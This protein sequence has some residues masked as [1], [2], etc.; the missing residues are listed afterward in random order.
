MSLTTAIVPLGLSRYPEMP[1]LPQMA[2]FL[3][4]WYTSWVLHSMASA[5]SKTSF[6][7]TLY[8]PSRTIKWM[9]P[10]LIFIIVTT[11]GSEIMSALHPF[12]RCTPPEKL[13]K[14][15]MPG[16]CS[17][18]KRQYTIRSVSTSR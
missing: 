11:F 14:N 3:L 2:K 4:L 15:W 10:V 12:T 16:E 1:T 5:F 9:R 8:R 18:L 7:L 6:A 13:W 17:P